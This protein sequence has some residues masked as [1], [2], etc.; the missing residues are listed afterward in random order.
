MLWKARRS[1]TPR[2]P[3]PHQTEIRNRPQSSTALTALLTPSKQAPRPIHPPET[4]PTRFRPAASYTNP[5]DVTHRA[6][7]GA[8]RSAAVLGHLE[9]M[10]SGA[11]GVGGPL[12][13]PPEQ[14][15]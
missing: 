5:R 11:P 6:R 3:E 10:Q 15:V 14:S 9:V 12:H 4:A 13:W 1:W 8:G 2:W 7:G